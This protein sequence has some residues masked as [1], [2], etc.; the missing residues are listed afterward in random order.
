[1]AS[2]NTIDALNVTPNKNTPVND[3]RLT[4]NATAIN[5]GCNPPI[6]GKY[7]LSHSSS[8][9]L[10]TI[11]PWCEFHAVAEKICVLVKVNIF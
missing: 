9:N 4:M 5:V 3:E 2:G 7:I 1:M 10:W 11:S 8:N 6:N